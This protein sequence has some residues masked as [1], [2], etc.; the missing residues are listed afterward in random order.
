MHRIEDD[1]GDQGRRGD[2]D[3]RADRLAAL[4]PLGAQEGALGLGIV[5]TL[6]EQ[7]HGPGGYEGWLS[8][9]IAAAA[10]FF[11]ACIASFQGKGPW[12]IRAMPVAAISAAGG[13]PGQAMKLT[14]SGEAAQSF[15]SKREIGEAGREEAAG[16]GLGIG[17]GAIERRLDLG[18][19]MVSASP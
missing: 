8:K 9:S 19:V 4:D 11:S 15:S 2:E 17:P 14:G 5:E 7:A 1:V 16:A 3:Q 6:Q 12:L 10:A 13:V 18:R